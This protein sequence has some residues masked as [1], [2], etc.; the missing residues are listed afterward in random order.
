MAMMNKR[1]SVSSL[2][3]NDNE[4]NTNIVSILLG[5]SFC[6]TI[7]CENISLSHSKD[8]FIWTKTSSGA[9]SIKSTWDTVKQRGIR[10]FTYKHAWHPNMPLKISIF[11]WKILQKA[12]STYDSVQSKGI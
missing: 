9:F 6:D 1:V 12:I 5:S 10:T 7:K 2:F 4:I 8:K 11:L 3:I